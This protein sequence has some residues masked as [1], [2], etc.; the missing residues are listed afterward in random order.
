M[1]RILSRKGL[2]N[3]EPTTRIVCTVLVCILKLC[4]SIKEGAEEI[5]RLQSSEK[6]LVEM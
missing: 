1:Y 5:Y 2:N 3:G 6:D 4:N